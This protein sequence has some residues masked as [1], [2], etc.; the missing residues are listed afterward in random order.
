M[1]TATTSPTAAATPSLPMNDAE[2]IDFALRHVEGWEV[3]TF[4]ADW[5]EGRNMAGWLPQADAEA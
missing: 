5:R 1:N 4:L 3:A 2:A